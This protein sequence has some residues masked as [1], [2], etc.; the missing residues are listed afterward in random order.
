MRLHPALV[1]ATSL[2]L[3]WV[4]PAHAETRVAL[5]IGN[6]ACVHADRLTNPRNDAEAVAAALKRSGFDTIIGTDLD[7]SGME[8]ATI[9][10]ARGARRADVAMF[11]CSGHAVQFAGV[12]YLM[13]VDARLTDEADLR[14]M[15]RVDQATSQEASDRKLLAGGGASRQQ[16]EQSKAALQQVRTQLS[17]LQARLAF[18]RE[19][20]AYGQLRAG[21]DGVVTAVGVDV[22]ML[23]RAGQMVVEVNRQFIRAAPAGSTAK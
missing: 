4:L 17:D 20:L 10:F 6:S 23:V 9:R 8:E 14:R 12:N 11:Y 7:K 21:F 1:G 5:A 16:Y 3:P 18:A 22:G 15:V 13:P 19:Q 2:L